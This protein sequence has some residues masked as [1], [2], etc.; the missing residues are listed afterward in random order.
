MIKSRQYR[1]WRASQVLSSKH[2]APKKSLL[3]AIV[4]HCVWYSTGQLSVH[5]HCTPFLVPCISRRVGI[6]KGLSVLFTAMLCS[7]SPEITAGQLD[8]LQRFQILSRRTWFSFK[9]GFYQ[10]NFECQSF[11]KTHFR[12]SFKWNRL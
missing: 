1:Y 2:L 4:W 12:Y 6:E 8:N 5:F 11:W 7:L 9:F 10:I 3:H